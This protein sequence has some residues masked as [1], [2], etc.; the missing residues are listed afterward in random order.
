M[1][2]INCCWSGPIGNRVR[3]KL[4]RDRIACNP[5]VST[6]A[7]TV[8]ANSWRLSVNGVRLAEPIMFMT[9]SFRK[10]A[11]ENRMMLADSAD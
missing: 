9:E 7:S 11:D 4:P 6:L 2:S 8:L 10:S 5:E 3:L 1:Y